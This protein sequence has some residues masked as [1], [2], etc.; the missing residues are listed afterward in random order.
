MRMQQSAK[1]GNT[2]RVPP[3]EFIEDGEPDV[4]V[5]RR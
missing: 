5:V 2:Q 4:E 3:L 1:Q